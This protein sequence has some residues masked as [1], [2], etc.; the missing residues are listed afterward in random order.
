M[1]LGKWSSHIWLADARWRSIFVLIVKSMETKTCSMWQMAM[2]I[3]PFV[4]TMRVVICFVT[5]VLTIARS[6]PQRPSY[7]ICWSKNTRELTLMMHQPCWLLYW[8]LR[9]IWE[10][11]MVHRLLFDSIDDDGNLLLPSISMNHYPRN[12]KQTEERE[13]DHFWGY[14]RMIPM[15]F[16]DSIM[17]PILSTYWLAIVWT[18]EI[19]SFVRY[20]MI[21]A[22][23]VL[24]NC[25]LTAKSKKVSSRLD[26]L[27]PRKRI[28][29]NEEVGTSCRS[30]HP[31]YLVCCIITIELL[32]R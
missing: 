26:Y 32:R 1:C 16:P 19:Y 15:P 2:T 7:V 14:W 13:H 10:A 6:S 3:V 12:I 9:Q 24:L 25:H 23:V 8:G 27:K 28:H 30:C 21:F 5:D 29:S 31:L 22:F 18:K 4:N 20:Y 11:N 17:L